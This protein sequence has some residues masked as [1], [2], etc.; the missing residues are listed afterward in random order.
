VGA[1]RRTGWRACARPGLARAQNPMRRQSKKH[2]EGSKQNPLTVAQTSSRSE[3][4]H[5]QRAFP[6]YGF[7]H[8]SG[9]A[10]HA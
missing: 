2:K 7:S 4:S 9:H 5:K 6:W 3:A 8:V 10:P 1:R